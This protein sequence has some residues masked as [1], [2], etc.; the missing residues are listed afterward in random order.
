VDS[1]ATIQLATLRRYFVANAA[2]NHPLCSVSPSPTSRDDGLRGIYAVC[3]PLCDATRIKDLP[4]G[5]K[6]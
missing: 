2:F 3:K 5:T 1:D 6:S 4:S